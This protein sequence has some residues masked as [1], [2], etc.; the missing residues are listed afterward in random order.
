MEKYV[1]AFNEGNKDMREL[2]G[3]KGA[4]LAEMTKM[5]LPVPSG[6]TV[7]TKACD[8]YYQNN[9][10]ITDTII[11]QI[12]M[13][14]SELETMSSKKLGDLNNPLLLSV[15]SGG[16]V[17]MPGMMDTVLNVGLTD[18][19]VNQLASLSPN[20]RFVYDSYR[21]FISMYADVV[22]H[23]DK[24]VFENAL[25]EYK[26]INNIKD[27]QDLTVPDLQ[28]IVTIFKKLYQKHVGKTFSQNPKKHL[29]NVIISVFESWNNERAIEYRNINN[30]GNDI[31]TAVNVQEMV[32]G[33]FNEQS[34]TGVVF[35]RNPSTGD[36]H[37]YGEFLFNAQGEDIVAG[38]R[39][40]IPIAKL[41]TFM[42]GLYQ[43]LYSFAKKLENHY[44]DMQ[45]IEFTIENGKLYIL[46]TRT[47]KRSGLA[48]I[49]ITL[50]LLKTKLIDLKTAIERITVDNV[51]QASHNTFESDAITN[52]KTLFSGLSASPGVAT[53]KIYFSS[54]AIES[55][56]E[57]HK[58]LVRL[59]TSADDIIGMKLADA[60]VTGRG[61]MTSHAAVVARGMGKVSVTGCEQI[62]IN[63]SAKTI[64]LPNGQELHEGDEVSVDGTN[65]LIYEGILPVASHNTHHVLK[66]L[67]IVLNQLDTIP[68][69]ANAET[70]LDVSHAIEN[71]ANGIGLCRTEHMFFEETRLSLL[72]QLI[73][74]NNNALR[75][76]II[77]KLKSLHQED[78]IELIN[79]TKN[80]PLTIRYLDPPLHEFV[81][82]DASELEQFARDLN[83]T[84]IELTNRINNLNEFNPMMGNRGARLLLSNQ[85]ITIMQTE[86]IAG[87]IKKCADLNPEIEI[88]I[89]LVTS[90]NEAIQLKKIIYDTLIKEKV[91]AK[92]GIMIETPRAALIA[93]HLAP[94]F[95]F[96]SFGTNDLT[97]LTYGISRDDSNKFMPFYLKNKI[98]PMDPFITI[99]EAGVGTLM[100]TAIINGLKVNPKLKIGICGEHAGDPNSINFLSKLDLHYLSA[101]PYRLLNV[102]LLLAKIK[103]NKE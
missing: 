19:V 11:D 94:H 27:D 12:N 65:G 79:I 86:A 57:P 6:F 52:A 87:A 63:E 33:N 36:N 23:V 49:V 2:L 64:I 77:S 30:I 9:Q 45:D 37:L 51:N 13:A 92:I 59:E 54:Q 44:Q 78:F 21:R 16:V 99:D 95:D 88:M 103:S 80:L 82:I 17:S 25:N 89:P 28:N 26:K 73:L 18:A 100:K 8:V 31:K 81:K 67:S 101:S 47:G 98:F 35:S 60:I 75:K 97:Q 38:V 69:L 40:P 15:R 58:I 96:F 66:D 14:L 22:K 24:N 90:Y 5:G 53:G 7:T 55:S 102:K 3:G 84:P 50:D 4:N 71:G 62:I 20:P 72:K 32:Y 85:E 74:V 39:T 10:T 83:I 41:E 42:P 68:V 76:E 91:S 29:I 70:V 43:E 46:Q 48:N 1:Y 56:S 61:G 34:A 93:H